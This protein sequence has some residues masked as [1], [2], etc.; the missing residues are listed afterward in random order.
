MH[1]LLGHEVKIGNKNGEITNILGVGYEITFFDTNLGK[2]FIDSR[3]IC[4]YLIQNI[5]ISL[6]QTNE[7]L[8]R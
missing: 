8:M 3:D 2:V 6:D 5:F 7:L 1:E 4:S